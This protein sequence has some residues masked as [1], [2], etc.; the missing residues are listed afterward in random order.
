MKAARCMMIAV[1]LWLVLPWALYAQ[2]GAILEV[3]TFSTGAIGDGLP[4][5]WHPLIFKKIEKQTTYRL[6]QDGGATV[7]QAVSEASASGLTR[8]IT[9]NLNEYPIVQ[10][11]WKVANVL[12]KGTAMTQEGDDYPARLYLTFTYDAD[13]VGFF[14]KA[15]YETLKL[16]YGQYPPLAALTYIWESALPKGTMLRSP[17]TERVTMIAVESGSERLNQWVTEERNVY[18]DYRTAFGHEPPLISGVAIMTDTDNTG[19]SATAYYGDILFKK[20]P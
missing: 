3:G 17:Y 12:K 6:V 8:D 16:L 20:G 2:S 7:V 15:Q 4:E 9:I 10:W 18:Q 19:E 13:K 1:G 5:G 14:K 11:R